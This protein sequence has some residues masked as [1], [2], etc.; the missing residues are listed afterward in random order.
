MPFFCYKGQSFCYFRINKKDS[1]PYIGFTE[2]KRMVHPALIS[3]D[4]A[5]IKIFKI[6][7]I[8]IPVDLLD[9]ILKEATHLCETSL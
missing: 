5:R 7:P 2:G 8:D 4:R 9:E 3:G 1:T 6:D